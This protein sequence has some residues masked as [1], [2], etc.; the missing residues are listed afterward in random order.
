MHAPNFD[1]GH[2]DEGQGCL[3]LVGAATGPR[4]IRSIQYAAGHHQIRSTTRFKT[5]QVAGACV[6]KQ[7]VIARS[8]GA[9][10]QQMLAGNDIVAAIGASQ[11]PG[12]QFSGQRILGHFLLAG[13][14]VIRPRR[15]GVGIGVGND[16]VVMQD[17]RPRVLQRFLAPF[18]LAI[19]GLVHGHALPNLGG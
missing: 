12:F 19:G 18:Q 13:E 11:P 7:V 5:A 6:G 10:S 4:V 14:Q 9:K 1:V 8:T 16:Q 17:A 2:V 15:L 3:I